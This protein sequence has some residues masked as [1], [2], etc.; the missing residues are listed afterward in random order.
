VQE[1][2]ICSND[3]HSSNRTAFAVLDLYQLLALVLPVQEVV[4]EFV[5]RV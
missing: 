3:R 2:L 4:L 5:S 1:Q